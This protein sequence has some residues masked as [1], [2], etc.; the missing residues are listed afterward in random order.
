MIRPI[1]EDHL[2]AWVDG[3]LAPEDIEA[4]EIY[5]AAH[6]ELRE[7]WSQYAEQKEEL[8][9]AFARPAEQPTPARLR[10]AR[11]MAVQRRRRYRQSLHLWKNFYL[12]ITAIVL[13]PGA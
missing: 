9:A 3:R 1:G 4:V 7:R 5:F 11:L 10:V 6:P 13:I 8:R 2:Q 12:C